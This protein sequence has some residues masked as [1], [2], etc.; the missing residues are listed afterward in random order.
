MQTMASEKN[1]KPHVPL[2]TPLQEKFLKAH[3]EGVGV[4]KAA[5][6]AGYAKPKAS[7]SAILQSPAVA[8]ALEDRRKAVAEKIVYTAV[9][10]MNEAKEAMN[11][12]KSTRNANAYVKAVELRTKLQGLLVEKHDFRMAGQFAINIKGI[13]DKPTIDIPVGDGRL[14]LP[15]AA[16]EPADDEE[17]DPF[18]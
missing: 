14:A 9:E 12:A 8:G 7:L 5:E 4:L 3:A 2:P 1:K 15:L 16:Q 13:D 18:S 17:V 11:F 10:A 6:S